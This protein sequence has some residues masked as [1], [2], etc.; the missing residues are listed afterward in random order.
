MREILEALHRIR[1]EE[2]LDIIR[3]AAGSGT[4]MVRKKTESP[5]SH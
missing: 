2:A 1:T 5:L 3:K 4:I